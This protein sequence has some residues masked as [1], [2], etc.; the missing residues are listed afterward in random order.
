M[1]QGWP[2]SREGFRTPSLPHGRDAHRGHLKWVTSR[3]HTPS[4]AA[5][6]DSTPFSLGTRKAFSSSKIP[7]RHS[8]P[9]LPPWASPPSPELAQQLVFP[10]LPAIP[11]SP[12]SW[13]RK[14][15]EFGGTVLRAGSTM[16]VKD[17]AGWGR[18][19]GRGQ[20]TKAAQGSWQQ[21][22]CQPSRLLPL[23][24]AHV[25]P[26]TPVSSLKNSKERE[27]SA[28]NISPETGKTFLVSSSHL[29][30]DILR[31]VFCVLSISGK[32]QGPKLRVT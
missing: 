22:S 25:L 2:R 1:E 3:L 24:L 27:G 29:M 28:S 5:A 10:S 12:S 18:G 7:P 19:G 26:H 13:G 32:A 20:Q 31:L 4:W 9:V 16:G 15:S 30:C 8:L 11:A 14:R 21:P 6:S 23:A 17:G